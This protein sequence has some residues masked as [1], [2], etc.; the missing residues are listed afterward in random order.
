MLVGKINIIKWKNMTQ[1]I[2]VAYST[3]AFINESNSHIEGPLDIF[4]PLVKRLLSKMNEDGILQGESNVEIK[5]Y[6]EKLYNISIPKPTIEK[7]LG[8]IAKQVNDVNEGSFI[9]YQDGAFQLKG[10]QFLEIEQQIANEKS[11][12]IKLSKLFDAFCNANEIDKSDI[13]LFSFLDQNR[14]NLSKY[15]SDRSTDFISQPSGQS[16]VARFIDYFKSIPEV[17]QAIKKIYIGS[18][19]V[20]SVNYEIEEK[21]IDGYLLL[22]TNFVI[23]LHDLNT[24]E[25]CEVCK[26]SIKAALRAGYK[27]KILQDTIDE[28]K[29]LLEAKSRGFT[30]SVLSRDIFPEDIYNACKRRNLSAAD[31]LRYADNLETFIGNNHIEVVY[32]TEKIKNKA[33]FSKEYKKFKKIRN[34]PASALHDAMLSIYTQEKRGTS[35]VNDFFQVKCWIVNSAYNRSNRYERVVKKQGKNYSETIK[36][37]NL[38]NIL[39]LS[40]PKLGDDFKLNRIAELGIASL[41]SIE[42]TSHL[43]SSAVIR[44]LEENI[45]KYSDERISEQ[46]V[47]RLSSRLASN[48]IERIETLNETANQD[49]EKFIQKIKEISK[50]QEEIEKKQ[51][52]MIQSTIADYQSETEQFQIARQQIDDERSKIM[53]AKLKSEE[54]LSKKDK[55]LKQTTLE[56]EKAKEKA[57]SLE[58]ELKRAEINKKVKKWQQRS[59]YFLVVM[60]VIYGAYITSLFYCC[61]WNSEQVKLTIIGLEENPIYGILVIIFTLLFGYACKGVYDRHQSQSNINNYIKRLESQS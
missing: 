47:L 13:D 31:L 24:P 49:K 28:V 25:S 6:L 21:Y 16:I 22:D 33:R 2:A 18:L 56:L 55:E 41:V 36:A 20:S 52:A 50:K 32:H 23:A 9:L 10:Y 38:L 61:N 8:I 43:P 19:L 51:Q 40:N 44:E 37:D 60:V 5:D 17:Y 7:I 11:D 30:S 1:N 14:I 34:S 27:I 12:I 46:D 59:I 29:S 58:T 53:D 54:L 35:L 45:V 57:T 39:W 48:Q 3:L 42:L 15:L 26:L 4:V